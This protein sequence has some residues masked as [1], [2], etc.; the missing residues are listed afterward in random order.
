[1][2]VGKLFANLHV[3]KR[4]NICFIVVKQGKEAQDDAKLAMLYDWLF[5][6]ER[7]DIDHRKR[8]RVT[9]IGKNCFSIL[10]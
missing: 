9:Q 4:G 1:M 8:P 5:F 10:F 7:T 6:D 2:I 3:K